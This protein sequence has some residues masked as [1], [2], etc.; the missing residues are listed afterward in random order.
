MNRGISC[1]Q[2]T[3]EGAAVSQPVDGASTATKPDTVSA[4]TLGAAELSVAFAAGRLSPLDVTG[5]LLDRISRLDPLLRAFAAVDRT[6]ALSAAAASEAR[7]AKGEPLSRLDGVPVSIKDSLVVAGLPCR[8]GSVLEPRDPRADD[9]TPVARLRA[10]GAVILGKTSVPEYTLIGSCNSPLTGV[11]RNPWRPDLTPGGSSG[12]AVAAVA[13]GLG[14]LALGTDGGGSIRRPCAL[15]G[16]VGLKPSWGAV[17]RTRGLP[18]LLPGLEVVGPIARSIDDLILAMRW[19]SPK[20]ADF[21][22]LADAMSDADPGD[23]AA[24]ASRLP[25]RRIVVWRRIGDSPVD[26]AVA[27]STDAFAAQ[28]REC[29]HEVAFA[30]APS[31]VERFNR[32][33]WSVI[34]SSG[35]A[36]YLTAAAA[37]S[38]LSAPMAEMLRRGRALSDGDRG[39]AQAVVR[40]LRAVMQALLLEHDMV[41]TPSSAA[42]PWRAEDTHPACIDGQPVDGRGHAVFTAFVNATGLPALALP[43]GFTPDGLPVG[44]QLVGRPGADAALCALGRELMAGRPGFRFPPLAVSPPGHPYG[45]PG[46]LP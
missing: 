44:V 43:A 16:L 35:L 1:V 34:A 25:P 21:A 42:P 2:P 37:E 6:G 9:E 28:L 4:W 41:L 18:E 20:D 5:Q 19:L 11:T 31:A 24:R 27:A 12:G 45:N 23:S 7:W 17:E 36:G 10:A 33:A 26:P 15:T 3:D 46:H 32:G 39:H 22:A 40:E 13:A 30:A 29:G 14:P 38:A 8:W